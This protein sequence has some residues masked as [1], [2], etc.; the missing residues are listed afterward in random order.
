MGLPPPQQQQY[1]LGLAGGPFSLPPLGGGLPPLGGPVPPLISPTHSLGGAY[2]QPFAVNSVV[3][4]LPV[5][6]SWGSVG[7]RWTDGFGNS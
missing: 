6:N 7:S 1:L 5:G 2:A 4:L 3:P